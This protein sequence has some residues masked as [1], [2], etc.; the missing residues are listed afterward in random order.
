MQITE[1][2]VK[3]LMS[4]IWHDSGKIYNPVMLFEYIDKAIKEHKNK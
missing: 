1:K 3:Q 4:N 2:E